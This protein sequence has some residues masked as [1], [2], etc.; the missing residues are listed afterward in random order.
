MDRTASRLGGARRRLERVAKGAKENGLCFVPGLFLVVANLCCFRLGCHHCGSHTPSAHTHHRVQDMIFRPPLHPHWISLTIRLSG[1]YLCNYTSSCSSLA[2][3]IC[4]TLLILLAIEQLQR[5]F[6]T[7]RPFILHQLK[8][9]AGTPNIP[10]IAFPTTGTPSFCQNCL[11]L[12]SAAASAS[13]TPELALCSTSPSTIGCVNSGWPWTVKMWISF[14][15]ASRGC[16]L[17]E[18][19]NRTMP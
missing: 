15:V 7:F 5:P 3:S 18:G 19:E 10:Q 9:Y 12:A 16:L 4:H 1:I 13:I 6:N 11:L 14:N 17:N 2:S 8:S